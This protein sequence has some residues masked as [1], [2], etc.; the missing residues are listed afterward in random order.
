LCGDKL[1]IL[2]TYQCRVI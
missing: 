1:M 2:I